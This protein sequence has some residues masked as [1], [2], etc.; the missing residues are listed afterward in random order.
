MVLTDIDINRFQELYKEQF[1][2]EICKED[3]R[4]QGMK[5]LRLVSIVYGPTHGDAT[6][7]CQALVLKNDN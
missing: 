4:E 3:A 1:G 5:L 2:I 7:T 6:P